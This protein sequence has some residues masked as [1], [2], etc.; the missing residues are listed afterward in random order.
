MSA[1][2]A[3]SGRGGCWLAA[4]DGRSEMA[5]AEGCVAEAVSWI[6]CTYRARETVGAAYIGV[7]IEV[8]GAVPVVDCP[9][10]RERF[11]VVFTA[12]VMGV[13]RPNC[14]VYVGQFR[15]TPGRDDV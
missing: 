7:L 10:I 11:V 5:V 15:P 6:W 8:T 9:C 4:V 14:G 12:V 2:D 13:G 3:P 1:A